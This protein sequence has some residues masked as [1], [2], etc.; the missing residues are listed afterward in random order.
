MLPREMQEA[1]Q[2]PLDCAHID[3]LGTGPGGEEDQ[4]S[5]R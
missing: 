1:G 2:R 5:V 4:L 3:V